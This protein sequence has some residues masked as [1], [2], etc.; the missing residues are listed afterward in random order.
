MINTI[1]NLNNN[2]NCILTIHYIDLLEK[3]R[4]RYYSLLCGF[5]IKQ[6]SI[7][8]FSLLKNILVLIPLF[9][10]FTN[11]Y[12]RMVSAT[13]EGGMNFVSLDSKKE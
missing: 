6:I 10:W 1:L 7:F 8:L 3:K 9:A 5:S 13:E 11:S 4:T 12:E 2:H